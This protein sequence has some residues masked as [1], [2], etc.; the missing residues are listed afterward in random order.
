MIE[1]D[2]VSPAVVGEAS[3][4]V[5]TPTRVIEPSTAKV[6]APEARE[7]SLAGESFVLG[8]SV[9]SSLPPVDR[10]LFQ[11][12]HIP[13]DQEGHSSRPWFN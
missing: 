13:G 8:P 7:D 1:L 11:L 2:P 10:N 3:K 12:H 6:Q 5:A 4:Q 9:T